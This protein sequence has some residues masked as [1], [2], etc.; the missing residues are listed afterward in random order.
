[1]TTPLL[2]TR[3]VWQ[4]FSSLIWCLADWRTIG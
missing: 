3:G 2:E 1:M 4:R